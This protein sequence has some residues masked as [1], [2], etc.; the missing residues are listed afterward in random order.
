MLGTSSS[1]LITEGLVL[2]FYSYDLDVDERLSEETTVLVD[3]YTVR[4]SAPFHYV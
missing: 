4:L 1:I 3:S 2:I